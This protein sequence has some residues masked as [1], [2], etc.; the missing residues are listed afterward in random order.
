MLP[1]VFLFTYGM[2]SNGELFLPFAIVGIFL[3]VAGVFGLKE[4]YEQI[5]HKRE[6][7][8]DIDSERVNIEYFVDKELRN[9]YLIE[10][11]NLDSFEIKY[12]KTIGTTTRYIFHLKDGE[13]I[14]ISEDFG[15][16]EGV[17]TDAFF[18]HSY[19]TKQF[20]KAVEN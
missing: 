19:F 8:F 18:Q 9:S 16:T 3:F 17:I 12:S 1:I 4:L 15:K 6:Y 13:T 7:S 2:V 10:K 5:R 11:S 20:L 14:S